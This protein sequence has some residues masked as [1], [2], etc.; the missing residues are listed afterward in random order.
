MLRLKGKLIE[1]KATYV[2]VSIEETLSMP[3]GRSGG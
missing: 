1:I 3:N 2:L